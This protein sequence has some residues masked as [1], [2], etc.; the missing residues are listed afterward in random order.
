VLDV[1]VVLIIF[2]RPQLTER[3]LEAIAAVKPR[4]LLVVADGPRAD[5]PG[6]AEACA[7]ARA[8][9]DRVDWPCEVIRHFSDVNLG[10]GICPASGITWAF[11]LVEEAIILEDD[12]IPLP[13]F[14]QYAEEL[15][16]RYRD[17]TRVVHIGAASLRHRPI[18]IQDSYYF[19]RHNVAFGAF[20]TWRRAWSHFDPAVARWPALR[21][22]S[23]L[24]DIVHDRLAAQLWTGVFDTTH[25]NGGDVSYWDYQWTF[26][27]WIQD[28]LSILPRMNM[29]ANLGG[30]P[31]ATHFGGDLDPL[32]NVPVAPMEFPL[33][34]PEH[35]RLQ[36]R[37]D[38]A[39]LNEVVVSRLRTVPAW[40]V[41]LSR[42]MPEVMKRYLRQIATVA[43]ERVDVG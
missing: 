20:A 36:P 14:F 11:S 42:V 17:D 27:C 23:W 5:R 4:M 31:D 8:V 25:A 9:I 38:R 34:H 32:L 35:V 15:L 37:L 30:G 21:D 26:A 16:R 3:V 12:C 28:G 40:R 19:S 22:T 29:A 41:T 7:A 10:C 18:P 43:R 24:M 6:E 33:R 2:K 13:S 1:P 39:F